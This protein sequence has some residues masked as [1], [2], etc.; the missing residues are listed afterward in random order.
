M[1]RIDKMKNAY[2]DVRYNGL[3]ADPENLQYIL[4]VGLFETRQR[5]NVHEDHLYLH[6]G[7]DEPEYW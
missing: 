4:D 2:L 1:D 7:K 3:Y 6:H 5:L